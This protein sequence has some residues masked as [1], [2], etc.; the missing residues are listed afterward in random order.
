MFKKLSTKSKVLLFISVLLFVFI[1][2]LITNIY[3][4]EKENLSREKEQ[5]R[6]NTIT[7]YTNTLNNYE[8]SY[9][10]KL[11]SILTLPGV[12]ESIKNHDRLKL[13]SL[14]KE[15]WDNLKK[16]N[17]Y[18]KILHFHKA[19]GYTLLRMH[20]PNKYDDDIASKRAMCRYMHESKKAISGF[21]AGVHLLGYRVMMPVFYN[22]EYI[23][24]IEI[25]IKP[26]FILSQMKKFSN[27]SGVIFAKEAD[28]F[29]KKLIDKEKILIG[30]YRLESNSLN[31]KS[32]INHLPDGY[33][34][35]SD[36]RVE[37]DS[38]IYDVYLFEHKDF[39]GEVSAK[40]LIFNDISILVH[41][42]NEAI[43]KI[44]F[45]SVVLFFILVLTIKFG[46]EKTL[47]KIDSTNKE[48]LHSVA[49]LK[50]HQLAMDESS[51][52]T[53]SDI[54]GQIT[55]V[56]DNFCKVTG[57]T[58]EEAIGKPHSLL[59]HPDNPKEMF[60]DLWKTIRSK[61]VWKGIMKNRG[62][63]SDYWVDASILPILDDN[64]DIV[65]YIAIRHDITKMIEQQNKLD[66]IANTDTLTGLGSRYKLVQDIANSKTPALAILNVDSFSQ[67]NDFYG[68]EKGDL[69]IVMLA[70][71]INSITKDNDFSLY[72][73]QGDEFVVFHKDAKREDFIKDILDIPLQ[74]ATK[75]IKLDEEEIYL[76]LT[77]AISFESNEKILTTA[78]MALKIA[79]REHKS[80]V[81]YSDEISL[82][83]EYKNNIKWAKKI[84]EAIEFDKI[85]P[86]F[87]PIVN[88]S[89]G[90][91]EKYESLVR[92]IDDD[93]KLISPY[94]FLEISKKTKHYTQ[95][96]KIMIQKSFDMFKDKDIEFSINLTI[97]DILNEQIN[98]FIIEML[99][100]YK[101][102][103]YVVFEIVESESI[104]NFKQVHN[105]IEKIKSY[106]CKIAIDDFGTGYS[107]FE[108]L[109]K[110]NADYIKIDGSMIKYIDKNKEAQLVVSTIVDFAKKMGVKTIAEFVENENILKEVKKLGIDYSQGYHFRAPEIEL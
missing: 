108:Y 93:G 72:H 48:L 59:R 45:F 46:F 41:N 54:K 35:D 27:V 83:D 49:F 37:K 22:S 106:N 64:N 94:F 63:Y 44:V 20:N 17:K 61:K 6:L 11:T 26:S 87:Q 100:K 56:N 24:A 34:L 13:Y 91:W 33:K 86:V 8:I 98:D 3:L 71:I 1:S 90:K 32:L 97:E 74:V 9:K 36:L 107:N 57:Y 52:V 18:V 84:K 55:Y 15:E 109:M 30:K 47:D 81:I 4:T 102:G 50:S 7:A 101:I 85:I 58:K 25:G 39:K 77:T 89:S 62:K 23:G 75:P 105:F 68:H 76:N 69:V 12:I 88:N 67:I 5:Y 43:L 10:S 16:E 79:K 31:D 66:N 28:I 92:L 80:V 78:D 42:F 103:S 110:L 2:I 70:S 21:E 29:S 65:E 51:I 73:L 19:D 40:T 14:V 38:K 95:I 99:D 60:T 104:E 82:N 53:K 96:T